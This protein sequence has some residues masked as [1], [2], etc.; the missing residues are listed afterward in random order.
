MQHRYNL[1]IITRRHL[2]PGP[3]RSRHPAPGRIRPTAPTSSTWQPTPTRASRRSRPPSCGFAPPHRSRVPRP[4]RTASRIP[5]SATI[6]KPWTTVFALVGELV[7]LVAE[8]KHGAD[9]ISLV[10]PSGIPR[11]GETMDECAAR[12][13]LEETGFTVEGLEALAPNGL[14]VASRNSSIRYYPYIARIPEDSDRQ[15]ARLD[16]TEH[17]RAVLM[18]LGDWLELLAA[19]EVLDDCAYSATFL[20][21]TRLGWPAEAT[22]TLQ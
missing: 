7:V 12:E 14:A 17:I 18:P 6:G 20:G 2:R 4:R 11:S 5:A 15:P 21:L 16:D 8:Y 22:L 1:P 19:G 3:R 13:Y 9:A 10:P